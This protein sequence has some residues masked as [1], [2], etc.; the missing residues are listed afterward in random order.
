LI[1]KCMFLIVP[2]AAHSEMGDIFEV[3]YQLV[4]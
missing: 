3:D 4:Y 1:F 2:V